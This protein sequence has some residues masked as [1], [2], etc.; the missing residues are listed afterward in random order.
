[1][2]VGLLD[3]DRFEF[4]IGHL[5][6]DETVGHTRLDTKQTKKSDDYLPSVVWL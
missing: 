2:E 1:M 3:L 5:K 6:H 4:L